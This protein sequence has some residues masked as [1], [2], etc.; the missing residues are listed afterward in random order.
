MYATKPKLTGNKSKTFGFREDV[1]DSEVPV[2]RYTAISSNI[3]QQV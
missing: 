3:N 1:K 2:C